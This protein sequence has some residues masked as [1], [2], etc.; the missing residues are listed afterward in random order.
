[1]ETNLAMLKI[2]PGSII[3]WK[4]YNLLKQA[5]YKY[6]KK[7]ELPY[8]RCLVSYSTHEQVNYADRFDYLWN[9]EKLIYNVK[10]GYT[11]EE[12]V[13]LAKLIIAATEK[14]NNNLSIEMWINLVNQVRPNTFDTLT[15]KLSE[16][17]NNKYY[18]R[19]YAQKI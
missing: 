9:G 19:N 8:N 17:S 12:R 10:K 18:K 11:A 14:Y 2:Y 6:V 15:F 16:L 13:M 3:V 7:Q 1:M 5:Y 4:S